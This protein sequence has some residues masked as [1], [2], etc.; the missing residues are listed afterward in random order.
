MPRNIVIGAK[1]QPEKLQLAKEFRRDMTPGEMVLW[2]HLR[3]NQFKGYHF[4][5]QQIID[6]FV[7][8]FYCHSAGLVIEVD[9]GVHKTQQEA[10][11]ERDQVFI[12]HGLRV[13]RVSE[14]DVISNTNLVLKKI[15][16]TL[17]ETKPTT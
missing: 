12:E 14:E 3:T 16:V 7:A 4:R 9:G 2:K 17:S 13:L 6:G 11:A 8:D 15:A 5:R 10:D 1:I